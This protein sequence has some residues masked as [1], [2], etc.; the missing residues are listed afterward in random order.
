MA[1]GQS[2]WTNHI[3]IP[4]Q[5][6]SPNSDELELLVDPNLRPFPAAHLPTILGKL[7]I[8]FQQNN[9]PTWTR[10]QMDS[11]LLFTTIYTFPGAWNIILFF[12]L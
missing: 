6:N 11:A 4:P 2:T 7:D 12:T 8:Q 3:V 9:H 10:V 1:I 5:L